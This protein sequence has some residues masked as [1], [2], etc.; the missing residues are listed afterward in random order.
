[1]QDEIRWSAMD[2]Y[3]EERMLGA[4][5]VLDNALRASAEGGLPDIAVSPSQGKQLYLLAAAIGAKRI[6]EIGTLGGYSTIWMARALPDDGRLI[7]IEGE[8][9]HAEVAR[10]NLAA[11]GLGDKVDI[12]IGTALDLLPKIE[13]AGSGPFDFTFID[14]DKANIPGYFDHAVRMSRPGALIL[15]DNVTRRGRVLDPDSTD[16]DVLGVRAFADGLRDDDR[17]EATTVQTVGVKGYDG[18]TM[19]LVKRPV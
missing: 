5:P 12:W 11:A 18:F 15:I 16:P 10:A 14:A 19:A 13:A 2:R 8:P 1:M 7:S 9:R 3:F 4:D 17:V 6:L